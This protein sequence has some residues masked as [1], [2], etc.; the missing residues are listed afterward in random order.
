M[1]ICANMLWYVSWFRF[2]DTIPSH[3]RSCFLVQAV[4]QNGKII[5]IIQ[6]DKEIWILKNKNQQSSQFS[7]YSQ[8]FLYKQNLPN[9]AKKCQQLSKNNQFS[10]IAYEENCRTIENGTQESNFNLS[11]NTQLFNVLEVYPMFTE[12]IQ[13]EIINSASASTHSN[14]SRWAYSDIPLAIDRA[15]NMWAKTLADS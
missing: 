12:E 7:L 2:N 10:T 14:T 15:L 6:S 9:Q 1:L 13:C 8:M 3:G 5:I 11:K 4:K